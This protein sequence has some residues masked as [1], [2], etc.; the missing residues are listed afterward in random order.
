MCAFGFE[1]N[2]KWTSRLKEIDEAYNAADFHTVI[3]TEAAVSNMTGN[4]TFFHDVTS[5][6]QYHEWGSSTIPWHSS[7]Q[8]SDAKYVIVGSLD[9]ATFL[10][11]DVYH[12]AG[13]TEASKIV[14]KMDVEGSEW[15]LVPHLLHRGA[16]CGIDYIFM[17]MHGNIFPGKPKTK[18]FI[19][20]LQW[21]L[22]AI[23]GCKTT[24]MNMDDESYGTGE[25]RQPLP[26]PHQAGQ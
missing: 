20:S 14:V 24:I 5:L 3:F 19:P 16:L 17:E 22:S 23:P 26:A 2:P 13:Q 18:C 6:P 11:R 21:I 8:S 10:I 1:P 15:Y 9:A 12:R 4:I 7:M 25:D